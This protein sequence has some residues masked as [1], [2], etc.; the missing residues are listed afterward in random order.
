M[1]VDRAPYCFS[2]FSLT[3]APFTISQTLQR[4]FISSFRWLCVVCFFICIDCCY[5]R[6]FH[7][8]RTVARLHVWHV[9]TIYMVCFQLMDYIEI[10]ATYTSV[11][12]AITIQRLNLFA[13]E[14]YNWSALT[15]HITFDQTSPSL[16]LSSN[17]NRNI[18]NKQ[19]SK[20]LWDFVNVLSFHS[21]HHLFYKLVLSNIT[22]IQSKHMYVFYHQLWSDFSWYS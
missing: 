15:K 11:C 21:C 3:L 2:S 14:A 18:E 20:T 4:T 6:C 5:F 8:T 12:K 1:K 7:Y 10:F 22:S 9:A 19:I 16:P 17:K 13:F